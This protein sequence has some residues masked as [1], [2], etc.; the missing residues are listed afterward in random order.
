MKQNKLMN[1]IP[2]SV[3]KFHNEYTC[4]ICMLTKATKMN[5]DYKTC[6]KGSWNNCNETTTNFM[7][8]KYDVYRP[9]KGLP[10]LEQMLS[11]KNQK[12]YDKWLPIVSNMFCLTVTHW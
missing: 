2:A 7:S 6:V 11:N 3:N 8:L 10:K 12:P 1:G 9:R 4:P 5:C